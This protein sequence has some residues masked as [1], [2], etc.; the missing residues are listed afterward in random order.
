MFTLPNPPPPISHGAEWRYLFNFT[1]KINFNLHAFSED[2]I[3][4]VWQINL[5]IFILTLDFIVGPFWLFCARDL[6]LK[7]ELTTTQ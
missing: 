6:I 2:R 4:S 5:I 1:V 3:S 7:T